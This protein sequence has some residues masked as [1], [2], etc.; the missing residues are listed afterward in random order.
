MR[1]RTFWWRDTVGQQGGGRECRRMGK[2]KQKQDKYG[3]VARAP[4]EREVENASREGQG[5]RASAEV[6]IGT[7]ATATPQRPRIVHRK[8]SNGNALLGH[9]PTAGTMW[10]RKHPRG[11]ASSKS[12]A[13]STHVPN[14]VQYRPMDR[15]ARARPH[16]PTPPRRGAVAHK[17]QQKNGTPAEKKIKNR[18]SLQPATASLPPSSQ[19]YGTQSRRWAPATW[20]PPRP[21]P[22]PP[23]GRR[24]P[25][26]K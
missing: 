21:W 14:I 25:A 15:T 12:S 1:G 2:W 5:N 18:S 23:G 13:S 9:T 17:R 4:A 22:P 16:P 6:S 11:A 8:Q 7:Q 20:S 26:R 10:K 3:S 19:T 24:R